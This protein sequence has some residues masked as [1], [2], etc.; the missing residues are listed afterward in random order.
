LRGTKVISHVNSDRRSPPGMPAYPALNTKLATEAQP[1]FYD[2][3]SKLGKHEGLE[4]FLYTLGGQTDS[5][6]P[7][8]SLLREFGSALNVLVPY[9]A[10]SAGTLICLGAD[11]V[12]MTE[13]SE[14]SPVDPATGN[15]FNPLDETDRNSRKAISVEDVASYFS[16]A[17]DPRRAGE[18]PGDKPESVDL[19]LAFEILARKVHPLALGNV[20]RSHKQ[21]RELIRRLLSTHLDLEDETTEEHISVVARRLTQER[22]SHTDILNRHEA[23]ELLGNGMIKF[24]DDDEHRLLMELYDEYVGVLSMR[25]TFVLDAETGSNQQTTL[26]VIGAF[27][28]T[29]S[30]S[31]IFKS[32]CKITKRS[33]F[34]PGIQ[35]SLQPGQLPPLVPG[36][37]VKMNIELISIGWEPNEEGI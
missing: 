33:A 35:I 9:K 31:F 7:L 37:P 1:Y 13:L 3:L 16:L 36:F 2:A 22:Y 30:T 18:H 17:K 5:V 12:V 34:P 19:D 29:E 28:E 10:H 4:L 25:K 21:I 20:D 11:E 8:V 24:A 32:T 15:Q 26:D 14:L 6:W 23:M 27:I